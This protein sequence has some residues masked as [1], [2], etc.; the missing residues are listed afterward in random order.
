MAKINS[1]LFVI[2]MVRLLI[3]NLFFAGENEYVKS[4]NNQAALFE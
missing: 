1:M 4:L 2:I 3:I